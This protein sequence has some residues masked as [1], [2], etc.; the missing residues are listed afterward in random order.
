MK[1]KKSKFFRF[2]TGLGTLRNFYLRERESVEVR[3]FFKHFDHVTF[4]ILMLRNLRAAEMGLH[5]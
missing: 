1:C 2:G 5:P 4:C 3:D